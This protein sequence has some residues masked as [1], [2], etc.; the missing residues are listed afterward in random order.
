MI[1]TSVGHKTGTSLRS[2][3][4]NLSLVRLK[5]FEPGE[6]SRARPSLLRPLMILLAASDVLVGAA[7]LRRFGIGALGDDVTN[8]Q[9]DRSPV[10]VQ[11]AS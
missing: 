8:P 5:L 10:A 1:S 2:N 7:V 11:P 9:W 3:P 4:L 6:S